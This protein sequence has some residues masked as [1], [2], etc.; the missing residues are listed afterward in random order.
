MGGSNSSPQREQYPRPG[1]ER[2]AGQAGIV[3][4]NRKGTGQAN[5]VD[6]CCSGR[7]QNVHGGGYNKFKK[8]KRTKRIKRTKRTKRTKRVKRVKR[9]TK[10]K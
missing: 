9:N 1:G 5:T 8:A 2:N 7:P 6:D 10:R 4:G 3:S